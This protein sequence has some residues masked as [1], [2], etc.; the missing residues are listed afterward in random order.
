MEGNQTAIGEAIR[1]AVLKEIE[2]IPGIGHFLAPRTHVDISFVGDNILLTVSGMTEGE[3]G[4]PG[5][6]GGEP[7]A[8]HNLWD[9]HESGQYKIE[10]GKT[11]YVKDAGGVIAHTSSS[12]AGAGSPY[13]GAVRD[14]IANLQVTLG[15]SIQA[16]VGQAAGNAVESG[17]DIAT[18]GKVKISA[19]A[20]GAVGG[21]ANAMAAAGVLKVTV[22]KKGQILVLGQGGRFMS[23]KVFGI[24]T[25]ITT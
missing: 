2:E 8:E 15:T 20:K 25:K 24:P 11:V 22:T 17:F 12:N 19:A 1:G 18:G 9:F 10:G 5:V 21:A 7:K 14:V 3:A 13:R 23:P 4:F 16:I 6:S